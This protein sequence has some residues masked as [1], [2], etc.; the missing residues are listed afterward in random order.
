MGYCYFVLFSD[1]SSKGFEQHLGTPL[2]V[3]HIAFFS[4]QIVDRTQFE[5]ALDKP[6]LGPRG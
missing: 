1:R 3:V 2:I 4:R 6:V 5:A